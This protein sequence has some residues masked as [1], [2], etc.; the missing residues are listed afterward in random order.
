MTT[1]DQDKFG[2][3][4]LDEATKCLR[5]TWFP[6]TAEMTADDFKRTLTAAADAALSHSV[7]SILVDVR[8]FGQNP[9]LAECNSWRVENIVPKY[10]QVL[11][12]FAWIASDKMPQLPGGGDVY[13]GEGETYQSRWFR[14]EAAAVA[15]AATGD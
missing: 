6:A 12:R 8:G 14:D 5:M 4:T 9:A 15:W 1:I 7:E 13:Q 2:H 10:N 3:I 11:K